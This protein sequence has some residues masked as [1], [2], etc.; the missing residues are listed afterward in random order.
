MSPVGHHLIFSTRPK[1][2]DKNRRNLPRSNL[3]VCPWFA[4]G[5]AELISGNLTQQ[6]AG[7]WAIDDPPGFGRPLLV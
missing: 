2:I 5:V 6:R 3:L 4:P 1:F 7:E